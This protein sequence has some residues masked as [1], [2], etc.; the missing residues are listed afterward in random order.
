VGAVH[1]GKT[2]QHV[3]PDG[4]H[5]E[6]AI[7]KLP[8][9]GDVWVG[10]TGLD[11]DEQADLKVHGGADKALFCYPASH[12]RHWQVELSL[13]EMGTGAF[14]ENLIMEDCDET[15]VRIGDIVA[16]GTVIAQVSQPRRPCWK[17]A[18][19][20]DRRDLAVQIEETSR[21]GWYLRVLQPGYL[22]A[23]DTVRLLAILSHEWTVSRAHHVMRTRRLDPVAAGR[24]RDCPGLAK[25]WV[26]DLDGFLGRS[27]DDHP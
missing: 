24:L 25:R 27:H 9:S 14:G 12:Y 17:P 16:V 19:L 10:P 11:G 15:N 18:R 8:R 13:P 21:T 2:A 6:S 3:R 4:R 7:V 20:W 26:A 1:S 5:W 22:R 23:G